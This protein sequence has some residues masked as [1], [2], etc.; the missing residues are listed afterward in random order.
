MWGFRTAHLD[1]IPFSFPR[2]PTTRLARTS[3]WENYFFT[4]KHT[5]VGKKKIDTKKNLSRFVLGAAIIAFRQISPQLEDTIGWI[6]LLLFLG[7][8][9]TEAQTAK[10]LKY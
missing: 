6:L 3:A 7:P 10:C 4:L 8:I 2:S 5:H 9:Q 1:G